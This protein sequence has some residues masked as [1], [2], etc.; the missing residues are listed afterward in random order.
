MKRKERPSDLLVVSHLP[1]DVR[2]LVQREVSH[3][4][5]LKLL[6]SPTKHDIN[7]LHYPTNFFILNSDN[8]TI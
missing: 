2:L 6:H 4:H 7:D 5:L 3:Y 8:I 1:V